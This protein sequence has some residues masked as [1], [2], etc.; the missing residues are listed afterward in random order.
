MRRATI[1]I[2]GTAAL[3]IGALILG[4]VGTAQATDAQKCAGDKMNAA[5][6]YAA[7]RLG[8]D[9]KA[10]LSGVTADYTKCDEKQAGSWTKIETKY[11]AEC[12]TTGD[13]SGVQ[14]DVGAMTACLAGNVST[15]TPAA[16]QLDC[17]P[18]PAGGVILDGTCWVLGAAGDSCTAACA[19]N[20]MAYDNTQT[21]DFAGPWDGIGHCYYLLDQLGAG[22]GTTWHAAGSGPPDCGCSYDGGRWVSGNAT[23]QAAIASVQRVCA[24]N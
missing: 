7:C 8:A 19:L 15:T 4:T 14:A 21:N 23:A 9:K 11:G 20:G 24:C 17:I 3:A 13:Q 16:M 12:P 2:T 1:T 18:C 22:N 5:A 6:A 10:E